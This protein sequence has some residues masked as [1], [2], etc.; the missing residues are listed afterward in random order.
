MLKKDE[1]DAPE[2]LLVTNSGKKLYPK[3]VQR[4]VKHYLGGVSSQQKNSPHV[5]RHSFATHML[6]AGAGLQTIKELL[7]HSSLAATQVYTHNTIEKLKDVHKKYHPN[8]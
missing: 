3:F 5:L 1:F 4:K 7:G 2:N 6:N 8:Y